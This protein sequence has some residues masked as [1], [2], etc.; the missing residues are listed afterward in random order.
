MRRT[1]ASPSTCERAVTFSIVEDGRVF[2]STSSRPTVAQALREAGVTIGPGDRVVPGAQAPLDDDGCIEVTH[3]KAVTVTLP[4][5]HQVIYTL[6]GSV[7]AALSAAGIQL[8]DGAIL[9]P[10]ADTPVSAGHV[11]A[12][13]A[14]LRV[15]RRRTGVRREPDR[16]PLRSRSRAGRDA[17]RG[18]TT[19][20]A[21]ARYSV[22]YV[23]GEEA[24]R[25]LVDEYYRPRAGRH[26][27]L[28]P[29]A[30]RPQRQR[31]IG[32]RHGVTAR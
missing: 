3:A 21:C 26:R 9:D 2:V 6:E 24:S 5:D 15:E 28:L 1:R 27:D 23:N 22:G 4:H 18:A 25:T 13:R 16:V 10:P 31:A 17:H 12:R 19:A 29:D 32:Q 14:T 7:G 20:C 8:P 30:H 11:R